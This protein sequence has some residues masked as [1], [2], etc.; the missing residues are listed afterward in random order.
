MTLLKVASLCIFLIFLS[1]MHLLLK[2]CHSSFTPS[3]ESGCPNRA[4]PGVYSLVKIK[5]DLSA[6]GILKSILNV[7]I[8]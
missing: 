1:L 7:W 6:E 8:S 4:G 5:I 3:Q 2:K